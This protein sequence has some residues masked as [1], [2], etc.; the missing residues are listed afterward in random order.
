MNEQLA[1]T[2]LLYSTPIKHVWITITNI[3]DKGKFK[4]SLEV[5][6]KEVRDLFYSYP[7]QNEG[8]VSQSHNFSWLL[9]H[10]ARIAAGPEP[11]GEPQV[12][13][14]NDVGGG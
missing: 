13:A 7:D 8:I 6:G 1:A 9:D 11:V 10:N 4:V 12:K 2:D 3:C 14:P 5:D